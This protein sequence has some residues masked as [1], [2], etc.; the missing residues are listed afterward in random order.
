M[1]GCSSPPGSSTRASAC[2]SAA[3]STLSMSPSESGIPS[4]RE[5]SLARLLVLP[6]RQADPDH[7]EPGAGG[8]LGEC[9]GDVGGGSGEDDTQGPGQGE[10]GGGQGRGGPDQREQRQR[11]ARARSRRR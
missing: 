9:G 2:Q 8:E 11:R 3:M 5:Q 6:G 7:V 10:Q 1:E 4:A